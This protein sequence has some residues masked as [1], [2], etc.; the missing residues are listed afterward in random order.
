MTIHHCAD[1]NGRASRLLMNQLQWEFGVLVTKVLKE[2]K[3]EYIQAFI[4]TRK[5]EDIEIFSSRMAE[6]RCRHLHADIDQFVASMNE[7]VVD[8][9]DMRHE[10]VDKCR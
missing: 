10:I 8:K 3:A 9:S 2:D 1:G 7:K 6:L 5:Q 4:D